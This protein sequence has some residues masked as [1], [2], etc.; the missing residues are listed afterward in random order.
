MLEED[1]EGN[2]ES[3]TYELVQPEE[4][5]DDNNAQ[6]TAD[7]AQEQL[8]QSATNQIIWQSPWKA[9]KKVPPPWGVDLQL[10]CEAEK[11]T[12]TKNENINHTENEKTP[13]EEQKS[14]RQNHEI[15]RKSGSNDINSRPAAPESSPGTLREPPNMLFRG[16]LLL[17]NGYNKWYDGNP[18]DWKTSNVTQTNDALT[19]TRAV[20]LGL[21]P[22]QEA[23]VYQDIIV[24][25][26][27]C[28]EL[29]CNFSLPG[30]NSAPPEIRLLWLDDKRLTMGDGLV[31]QL[32]P[33]AKTH[34]QHITC[35]SDKSPGNAVYAR[36]LIKKPGIGIFRLDTVSLIYL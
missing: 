18:V 3:L 34:Y 19:G 14:R 13:K 16:E 31:V 29:K 35:I 10:K 15:K 22:E 20:S 24:L 25:P 11:I 21:N 7:R 23:Y 1:E 32:T 4:P 30:E 36:L 2:S 26:G 8:P 9:E 12:T 6:K 5:P 27:H 33:H 28:Y 17:N